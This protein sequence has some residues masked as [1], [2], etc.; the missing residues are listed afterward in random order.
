M[1]TRRAFTL[2]ELLLAMFI[3]SVI[4]LGLH[5]AFR[6]AT[7]LFSRT[8]QPRHIYQ[9][10]R[11]ITETLRRELAA[12]YIPPP[13]EPNQPDQPD[14]PDQQ[15][16]EDDSDGFTFHT[17]NPSW[18]T[19]SPTARSA[20]ITYKFTKESDSGRGVLTRS[21]QLY[22]T[23]IPLALPTNGI[24]AENLSDFNVSLINGQNSQPKAAKISI[25]GQ[26]ETIQTTVPIYAQMPTK[27]ES[28]GE[29][30]I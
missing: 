3:T 12:L 16:T 10:A 13:L 29:Q 14:Q 4:V 24:I 27:E 2:I 23:E 15:L 30:Q 1:K 21:E 20:K 19:A 6:Q 5:A 28:S 17:L 22:A 26:N 18:N 7:M 25:T 11:L 8:Q 9:T